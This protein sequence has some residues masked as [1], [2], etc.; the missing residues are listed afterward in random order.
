MKVKELIKKAGLFK[1]QYVE[2]VDHSN[3]SLSGIVFKVPFSEGLLNS[4]VNSFNV[5]DS[6]VKIHI[7]PNW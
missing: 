7:S 4:T 3:H 2:I 6:G 5:S 1:G